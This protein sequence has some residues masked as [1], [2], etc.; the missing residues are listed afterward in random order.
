MFRKFGYKLQ[1]CL[2]FVSAVA[3]ARGVQYTGKSAWR[4]R[5]KIKSSRE[6]QSLEGAFLRSRTLAIPFV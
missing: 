5:W 4:H 3:A 1:W 2:R 6:S